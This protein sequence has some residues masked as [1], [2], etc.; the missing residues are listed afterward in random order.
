MKYKI[1]Y[2]VRGLPDWHKYKIV[3][4]ETDLEA[5]SEIIFLKYKYP[6]RLFNIMKV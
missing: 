5:K 3:N 2:K 1:E 6:E 4:L